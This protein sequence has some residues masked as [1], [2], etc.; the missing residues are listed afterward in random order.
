MNGFTAI[1]IS[2][3]AS[4][5]VD[6]ST[7]HRDCEPHRTLAEHLHPLDARWILA[8]HRRQRRN[9]AHS[10]LDRRA[11]QGRTET[12]VWSATERQQAWSIGLLE[13]LWHEIVC[14][15][16]DLGVAVRRQEVGRNDRP[17]GTLDAADLDRGDHRSEEHTSELQSLTNLVCR[18]L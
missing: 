4:C 13:A 11:R 14:L 18:L 2:F 6:A 1:S 12:V 8:Q 16:P 7:S 9:A 17:R 3:P 5:P 10:F 15:S